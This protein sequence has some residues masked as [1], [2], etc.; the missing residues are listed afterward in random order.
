MLSI[1]INGKH[2]R[3][4]VLKFPFWSSRYR[5]G[6]NR[7]YSPSLNT[8]ARFFSCVFSCFSRVFF[9]SVRNPALRH[10]RSGRGT[11]SSDVRSRH[12]VVRE[13]RVD[14]LAR[15]AGCRPDVRVPKIKCS[16]KTVLLQFQR[17]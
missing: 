1:H 6:S 15:A 5:R 10:P 11:R 4:R 8:R 9:D 13:G 7:Y 14:L 17:Y 16:M 3:N 12:V 2:S